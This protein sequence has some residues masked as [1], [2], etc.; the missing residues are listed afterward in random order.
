MRSAEL[1]RLA[2]V[3]VRALRHYHQVGVLAEPDRDFNGYRRYDVHDLVRVL[4]IRRLAALGMALEQM[5]PLLEDEAEDTS[6]VLEALDQELGAQIERLQEQ[7]QVIEQLKDMKVP[8]DLPVEWAGFFESYLAQGIPARIARID[9]DQAV[10]LAGLIGPEDSAQVSELYQAMTDPALLPAI[11]EFSE[12]FDQVAPDSSQA[13]LESL[14]DELMAAIAP[15]AAQFGTDGAAGD[16]PS[17][18]IPAELMIQH[19]ADLMNPAQQRLLELVEAKL[20]S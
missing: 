12:R 10:L 8:P 9:R 2:G 6:A 1:A 18:D 17:L 4:R 3:S 19:A 14:A 16:Q 20:A 7:R 15:L 11:V 13:E 5:V